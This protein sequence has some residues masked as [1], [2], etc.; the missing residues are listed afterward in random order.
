MPGDHPVHAVGRDL[1]KTFKAA[2]PG[3][4]FD[5]STHGSCRDRPYP[6]SI[7]VSWVNG[8]AT[9][10]VRRAALPYTADIK[11]TVERLASFD[12]RPGACEPLP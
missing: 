12:N 6:P 9:D 11:L 10:E 3:V 5:V 7:Y 4:K 1:R 2:F 8:P